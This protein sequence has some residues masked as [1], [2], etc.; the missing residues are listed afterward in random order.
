MNNVAMMAKPAMVVS[1]KA[2]MSPPEASGVENGRANMAVTAH[3]RSPRKS[4]KFVA[5]L[6]TALGV[7]AAPP[8]QAAEGPIYDVFAKALAPV[9]A[10]VFGAAPGQPGAMVVEGHVQQATGRLA[11]ARGAK[12]RL[13]IQA[14]DHLRADLAHH[15]TVLTAS[16][17]GSELWAA[18]PATMRQLAEAAG[19]DLSAPV[20]GQAPAPLLPVALDPQML[21]FL[22]VVFD[23]RDLG[24]EDIDGTPHRQLEFGFLPELRKAIG[25]EEFTAQA[26]VGPDHQPRRITVT[27]ADYSLDLAIEKLNFAEQFPATAWQPAEDQ[28]VLQ[29][30]ASALHQLFE[31]MLGQN[32]SIPTAL[33]E[34]LPSP[35][36]SN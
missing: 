12:L 17:T 35:A 22:P 36:G 21:V 33:A 30:P 14:P 28:D 15:G 3:T 23:V 20:T 6:A 10:A 31:K 16:R 11:A 13:A 29:L 5:C 25:A 24:T 1:W 19:L 4:G 18:P 2:K 9:A 26:W 34:E 8:L 7:L 32:L 27:G